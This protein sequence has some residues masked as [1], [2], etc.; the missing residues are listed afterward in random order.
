MKVMHVEARIKGEIK[1]PENFVKK[2][3]KKITVFTTIQLIDTLPKIIKQLEDAEKKPNIYK[4]GHTRHKGQILGCNVQKAEKYTDKE[5][6][7]FVYIGDGLFHPKALAW[8]NEDKKVY[9][10]NPF[11]EEQIIVDNEDIQLIKKRHKAALSKFYMST[12]I[13][14]LVTTKPGQ[15]YLKRALELKEE[16]P[17]KKFYYIVDNTIDFNSLEDFPFIECW[18]NTACPRIGFDDSIKIGKPII[19][20][21]EVKKTNTKRARV[22]ETIAKI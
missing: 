18:I 19:N 17:D 8:E 10:Y 2:L 22:D 7:A 1:L 3:P 9:A 20:L 13:G 5:F 12:H 21:E 6:D 4:T 15:F 14:V 11:T 16:Y